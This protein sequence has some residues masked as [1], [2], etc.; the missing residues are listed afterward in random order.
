MMNIIRE[1]TPLKDE[2][3][4]VVLYQ[5]NAKFDFPTHYH[6][7][8]EL[9][10]VEGAK[11][12]RVVG[13]SLLEYEEKDLVLVGPNLYHS[14]HS[15]RGYADLVV[16]IQFQ[17]NLLPISFQNKKIFIS[18]KEMLEKS[19][20]GIEFSKET[21]N[22]IGPKIKSLNNENGFQSILDFFSI[23]YEISVCE[24][25]K[26]LCSH[27]F[28]PDIDIFKSRRIR[29]VCDYINKNF[30]EKITVSQIA[31]LV[32]MTNSS[33]CHFFKKRTGKSLVEYINDVRIGHTS[34][35]LIESTKSIS[36]IC[37]SCGFNNL[38]N[39]NR[40][41]KAR[42]GRSPRDYRSFNNKQITK[43]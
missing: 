39:F 19:K 36:E 14:W 9:N 33:F 37:Y 38:S 27:A 13:E 18:I 34:V 1:I 17:E 4:F 31:K 2:D 40:V 43:Y 29:L 26:V 11:G 42:K 22:N 21:I 20:L 7:E 24:N 41:F 3:L 12:K 23:L 30:T 32:G 15:E 16:T 28:I 25:Q 10:Y 8:Y 5:P 35:Q 6:P